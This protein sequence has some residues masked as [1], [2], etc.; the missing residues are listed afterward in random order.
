MYNL[1]IDDICINFANSIDT[2]KI[3]R[4][5]KKRIEKR[6]KYLPAFLIIF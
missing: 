4:K 2:K 1:Q 3:N 5:L 6:D